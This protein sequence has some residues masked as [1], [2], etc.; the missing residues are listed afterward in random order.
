MGAAHL[1]RP[2]H[3]LQT[4]RLRRIRLADLPGGRSLFFAEGAAGLQVV[5]FGRAK[6]SMVGGR[7][8]EQSSVCEIM[9]G[10]TS[11]ETESQRATTHCEMRRRIAN[12]PSNNIRVAPGHISDAP[13]QRV[14]DRPGSASVD[15]LLS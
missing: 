4:L 15:V 6:G 5:A 9:R 14:H 3:L 11:I 2:R 8:R 1:A 10:R 7:S 12:L 13:S